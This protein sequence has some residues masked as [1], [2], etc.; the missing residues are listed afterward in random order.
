MCK[1]PEGEFFITME[2]VKVTSMEILYYDVWSMCKLPEWELLRW[3]MY[4][5]P[6]W[7]FFKM[8]YEAHVSYLIW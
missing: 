7:E 6:Q 1:L 4:K 5:L 3:I 2:H 8:I